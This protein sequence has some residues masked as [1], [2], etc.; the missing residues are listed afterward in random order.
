MKFTCFS[1]SLTKVVCKLKH[2]LNLTVTTVLDEGIDQYKYFQMSQITK[3]I[4]K[5]SH[6][7][8]LTKSPF[9]IRK[10]FPDLFKI[11]CHDEV[12]SDK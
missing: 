6:V 7:K 1:S 12:H 8:F 4:E 3:Q 9:Q 5:S 2:N 10:A 11:R